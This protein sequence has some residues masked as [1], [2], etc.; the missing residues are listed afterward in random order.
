LARFDRKKRYN[1]K[2]QLRLLEDHCQGGLDLQRFERPDQVPSLIEAYE[3]LTPRKWSV[4]GFREWTGGETITSIKLADE[5]KR[6]FL[7]SYVLKSGTKCIAYL[8]GRQYRDS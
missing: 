3:A 1:L 7:R 4:A 8:L 2:R 5:A 6:G